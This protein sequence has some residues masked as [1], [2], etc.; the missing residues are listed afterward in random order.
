MPPVRRRARAGMPLAQAQRGAT[1]QDILTRKEN[2]MATKSK[3]GTKTAGRKTAT[4]KKS[5]AKK[6]TAKRGAKSK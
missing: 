5:T 6:S 2:P 4:A 1:R 3:T